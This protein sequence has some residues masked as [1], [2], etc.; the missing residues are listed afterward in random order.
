[1][2][3]NRQLCTTNDKSNCNFFC[4]KDNQINRS[5]RKNFTFENE[6]KFF[7]WTFFL[8]RAVWNDRYNGRQDSGREAEIKVYELR[9]KNTLVIHRNVTINKIFSSLLF[10]S[11]DL[12]FV[13]DEMEQS[14]VSWKLW[15]GNIVYKTSD[16]FL[17]SNVQKV[18][19]LN[20]IENIK[21]TCVGI[22]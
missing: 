21:K 2:K 14:G 9:A 20:N 22:S 16:K 10:D 17:V 15:I 6:I 1:M 3:I 18:Q 11:I 19:N 13:L 7:G 4:W 8:F 5:N 12:V